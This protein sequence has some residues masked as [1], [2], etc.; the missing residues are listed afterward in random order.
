MAGAGADAHGSS[1]VPAIL[2]GTFSCTVLRTH[3]GQVDTVCS[4]V[5]WQRAG[6]G[7]VA[8]LNPGGPP[9]PTEERVDAHGCAAAGAIMETLR[10][11]YQRRKHTWR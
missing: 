2:H 3:P 4:M 1:H 5:L 7:A 11:T 10:R 9:D 8:P 6:L